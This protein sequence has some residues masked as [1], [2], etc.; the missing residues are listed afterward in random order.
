LIFGD[1][2]LGVTGEGE[3]RMKVIAF[4]CSPKAEKANT[5]LILN[6]FLKGLEKGGAQVELRYTKNLKITPCSGD[7][8]CWFRKPG[9][10][11]H[12]DDMEAL[13]PKLRKADI[14]VFGTPVY[15]DGVSS[16]MKNLM[17]RMLPL[18]LP[19]VELR[20]GHC[21]HALREGTKT[22]KVVLVSNCGFWEHDNFDP[23]LVHMRAFCRTIGR[24]FAGALLRPT[25]ETF[26]GLLERQRP[27]ADILEAAE[28]AGRQL[29][30][31]GDLSPETLEIISR[32]LLS[33]DRFVSTSNNVCRRMLDALPE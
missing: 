21:A 4:N 2:R 7:L 26:R 8:H 22:G 16:T 14:W 31:E 20:N 6:P 11:I 28:E 19:F 24:T 33:L 3:N 32:E 9:V 5:A 18:I 30:Q 1:I 23:L 12:R 29:I 10:C 27:V 25:G 15:F 17:D 13:Y